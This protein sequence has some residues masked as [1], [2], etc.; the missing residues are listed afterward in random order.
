MRPWIS[1]RMNDVHY[2]NS[3]SGHSKFFYKAKRNG[4]MVG[5]YN[6]PRNWYGY[7]L[8]Y[9]VE[10]VREHF[11][12][13]IAEQTQNYDA[14]GIDLDFHRIIRCFKTLDESN[15]VY[16]TDFLRKVRAIADQAESKWGHPWRIMVR[17]TSRVDWAKL[18]GFDVRLLAKEGLVDAFIPSAYWSSTDSDIPISQWKEASGGLPVFW[19]IEVNTV[20]MHHFITGDTVAGY[21][22]GADAAGA[23]GMYQYNTF[24]APWAWNLGTVEGAKANP[25]R[26]FVVTM[27][28]IPVP[29]G[30]SELEPKY[31]PLPV[32]AGGKA[33]IG[34]N[35]GDVNTNEPLLVFV[36]VKSDGAETPDETKPGWNKI[37]R[38]GIMLCDLNDPTKIL[39]KPDKPLISPEEWYEKN[40]EYRDNI[41]FPTGVIVEPDRSVKIYYGASDNCICVAES[42]IDE[43]LDFCL[44]PEPYQHPITKKFDGMLKSKHA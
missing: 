14:F 37:Y 26:R 31:L 27:N 36:G 40:P 20:N 3:P 33:E 41:I 16:M 21:M 35:V 7:A 5:D 4:W 23:D 2:A 28:D 17:L 42:T 19:G 38:A 29:L 22:L 25:T 11:L 9:A 44:N 43:L 1:F 15:C 12:G 24:N 8:D 34:V 32:A 18:Y 13:L 6:H 10:E 30:Y 39:A